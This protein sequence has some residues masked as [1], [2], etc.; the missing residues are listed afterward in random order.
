VLIVE[1]DESGWN[2]IYRIIRITGEASVLASGVS[3]VVKTERRR[4]PVNF[5]KG[6][7]SWN[8]MDSYTIL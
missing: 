8:Q 2:W 3:D 1:E 4:I 6:F 7:P 5:L